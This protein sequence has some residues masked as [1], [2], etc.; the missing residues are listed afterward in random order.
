MRQSHRQKQ[1]FRAFVFCG[2]YYLPVQYASYTTNIYSTSNF[3]RCTIQVRRIPHIQK[4]VENLNRPWSERDPIQNARMVTHCFFGTFVNAY[5]FYHCKDRQ[6]YA[7]RNEYFY[8]KIVSGIRN[9]H[10]NT[11]KNNNFTRIIKKIESIILK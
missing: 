11:E 3:S 2:Q 9:I 4:S 7:C 5:E 10:K 1:K 8:I 6:L